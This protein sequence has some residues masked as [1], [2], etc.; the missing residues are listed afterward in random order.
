[1]GEGKQKV[2]SWP[3]CICSQNP[4]HRG[5]IIPRYTWSVLKKYTENLS[6]SRKDSLAWRQQGMEQRGWG[7]QREEGPCTLLARRPLLPGH[8]GPGEERE[9]RVWESGQSPTRVSGPTCGSR[10]DWRGGQNGHSVSKRCLRSQDQT[11]CRAEAVAPAG[12]AQWGLKVGVHWVLGEKRDL[13]PPLPFS[14]SSSLRS[15]RSFSSASWYRLALAGWA[16]PLG[17]QS[18]LT[19]PLLH[20]LLY[21]HLYTQENMWSVLFFFHR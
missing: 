14:S 5:E 2:L 21:N 19:I 13:A 15:L 1:M 10:G 17:L 11:P 7:S 9:L 6:H 20:P 12:P 16:P 8:R 18:S 3:S 4:Y